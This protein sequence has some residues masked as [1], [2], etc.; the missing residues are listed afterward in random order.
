MEEFRARAERPEVCGRHAPARA[1]RR[2]S[3]LF[4]RNS[5]PDAG[6]I[7]HF[8][9][10]AAR[11]ASRS[12][13]EGK[14]MAKVRGLFA[15]IAVGGCARRRSVCRRA[16][17]SAPRR[18]RNRRRRH[19]AASSRARTDP[20]R[21]CGSSPKPRTCRP[22]SARSWSRTTRAGTC[23]RTCRARTTCSGCAATASST[24]RGRARTQGAASRC[25]PSS[26]R[27]RA[28]RPRSTPP[29]TGTR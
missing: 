23:C 10:D 11:L 26:R 5:V 24:R 20:K 15:A 12:Q 13:T 25:R 1:I 2:F 3:G 6:C 8:N 22:S 29:T 18:D 17:R 19:R 9:G 7:G 28:R 21:A 4:R 14:T 16:A 27:T